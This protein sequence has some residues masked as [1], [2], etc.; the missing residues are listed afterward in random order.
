MKLRILLGSLAWVV[1]V[2]ILHIWSNMGFERF[3]E[4]VRVSLGMARPTM[5][6]AF[7]PVT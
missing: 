1:L 4:E 2:T 7:L 3:A 6:V 5:R